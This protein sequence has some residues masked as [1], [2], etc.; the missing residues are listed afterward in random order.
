MTAAPP[1]ITLARVWHIGTLNAADK[2]G[3]YTQSLEGAG[4]SVSVHPEAW[5]E[6]ARLGGLPWHELTQPGGIR[7]LDRHRLTVDEL[8]T[9]A[10]WARHENLAVDAYAWHVDTCTTKTVATTR[11]AS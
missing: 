8:A 9:I 2:A 5:N 11:A 6:I 4:L 3:R 7:L 10:D 1:T